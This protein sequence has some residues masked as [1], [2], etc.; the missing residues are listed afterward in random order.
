MIR[1]I[2]IFDQI[3]KWQDALPASVRLHIIA[4]QIQERQ[5]ED[6][7]YPY[8]FLCILLALHLDA[9]LTVQDLQY[10]FF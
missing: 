5:M 10:I 4:P 7:L 1:H 9:P 3:G 6:P 2:R 8:A